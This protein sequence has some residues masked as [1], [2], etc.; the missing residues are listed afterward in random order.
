MLGVGGGGGGVPRVAEPEPPTSTGRPGPRSALP[1]HGGN[2]RLHNGPRQPLQ[3]AAYYRHDPAAAAAAA[4][5][6]HRAAWRIGEVRRRRRRRRDLRHAHLSGTA[7]TAVV[8]CARYRVP[9]C[10]RFLDD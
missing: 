3:V 2:R 5:L 7:A 1:H 10:G 9:N 8:L 6:H 4:L